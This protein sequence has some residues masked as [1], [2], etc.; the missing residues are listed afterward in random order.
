M[1]DEQ[2]NV[3]IPYSRFREYRE[4]RGGEALP[5]PPEAG[6]AAG[7]EIVP[8]EEAPIDVHRGEGMPPPPTIAS[9]LVQWMKR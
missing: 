4:G 9:A 8:A 7:V 6:G 5:M 3:V 2:A 1:T